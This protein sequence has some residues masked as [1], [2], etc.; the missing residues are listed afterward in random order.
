MFA[1]P[2]L[3]VRLGA[4]KGM[5]QGSF[6]SVPLSTELL[7][8]GAEAE[9]LEAEFVLEG[10]ARLDEC[11]NLDRGTPVATG[12]GSEEIAPAPEATEEEEEE[13]T[14]PTP[15]GAAPTADAAEFWSFDPE[16]KNRRKAVRGERQAGMRQASSTP[17]PP[18]IEEMT[19]VSKKALPDT[20]KWN[21]QFCYTLCNTGVTCRQ[22][23]KEVHGCDGEPLTFIGDPDDR[24]ETDSYIA[25]PYEKDKSRT[26]NLSN[27]NALRAS[28]SNALNVVGRRPSLAGTAL[29][30][31]GVLPPG[32][33]AKPKGSAM[34]REREA[35]KKAKRTAHGMKG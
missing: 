22:C 21:C 7:S 9:L 6:N 5:R 17:P 4:S 27:G 29:V 2:A 20:F 35:Q 16:R 30:P 28:M 1:H 33:L 11:S 15:R 10:D 26:S 3:P 18:H 24:S 23:G 19:A 12:P 8:D 32:I 25:P 14:P 34:Q 31:G 13:A